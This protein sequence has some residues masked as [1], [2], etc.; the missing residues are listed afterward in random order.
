M[1]ECDK[2]EK[3]PRALQPNSD[4][5]TLPSILG[6]PAGRAIATLIGSAVEIPAEYLRS[7]AGEVRARGEGRAELIRRLSN[8]AAEVY[9]NDPEIVGRFASRYIDEGIIKQSNREAIARKVIEKLTS[10]QSEGSHSFEENSESISDDWMHYFSTKAENISQDK[11]R[12]IW[13]KLLISEIK[14]LGFVSRNLMDIVEKLDARSLEGVSKFGSR[15]GSDSIIV[16]KE[17]SLI[18]KLEMQ[19][20]GLVLGAEAGLQNKLTPNEK[21]Y[22]SYKLDSINMYLVKLEDNKEIALKCL[23]ITPA[24]IEL[25]D[26]LDLRNKNIVGNYLVKA[27]SEKISKFEIYS[28]EYN[29]QGVVPG[30]ALKFWP[31]FAGHGAEF[32]FSVR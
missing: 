22:A 32:G 1:S 10:S 5:F 16:T 21:M 23:Y 14:K 29:E 7:W 27:L 17:D 11:F 2:D 9:E 28:V 31:S 18:E 6:G 3:D 25:I 20:I 4:Q 26:I 8:R 24:F 15:S 30:T 19:S 13:A 12:E